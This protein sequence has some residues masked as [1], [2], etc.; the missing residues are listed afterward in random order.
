MWTGP[1]KD[2]CVDKEGQREGTGNGI[3]GS[4]GEPEGETRHNEGQHK[5]KNETDNGQI[6]IM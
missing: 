3:E 2:L 6:D 1:T 5:H 4:E